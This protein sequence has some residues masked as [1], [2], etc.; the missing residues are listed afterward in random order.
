[1]VTLHFYNC[2]SG[3][4]NVADSPVLGKLLISMPQEMNCDFLY[5][6]LMKVRVKYATRNF[7]LSSFILSLHIKEVFIQ[8]LACTVYSIVVMSCCMSIILLQ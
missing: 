6:F 3:K 2:C 4:Y 8:E 7:N 1:M 5:T